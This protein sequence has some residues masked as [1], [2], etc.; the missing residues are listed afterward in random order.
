[1][2]LRVA[3]LNRGGHRNSYLALFF[4]YST[5]ALFAG[6]TSVVS[7]PLGN[8][9]PLAQI[10]RISAERIAINDGSM[11]IAGSRTRS[12]SAGL[13]VNRY[14]TVPFELSSSGAI[15]RVSRA[16][17]DANP[18]LKYNAGSLIASNGVKVTQGI[19]DPGQ[20]SGW[21]EQRAS[22]ASSSTAASSTSF[23]PASAGASL[24][25]TTLGLNYQGNISQVEYNGY[26]YHYFANDKSRAPSYMARQSVHQTLAGNAPA[27]QVPEPASSALAGLGLVG[28]CLGWR[29]ANHSLRRTSRGR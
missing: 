27:S 22:V 20:A 9:D 3:R 24:P 21:F 12:V 2:T 8:S 6:P 26:Q 17:A 15:Q 7:R 13:M 28:L 29:G 19:S 25:A 5:A 4:L 10:G 11:A 14:A 1:M 23:Q 18:T 16:V